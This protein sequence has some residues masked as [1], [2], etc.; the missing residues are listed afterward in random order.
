[1]KDLEEIIKELLE[2]LKELEGVI[3]NIKK[4]VAESSQLLPETARNIEDVM[5]FLEQTSHTIM[6]L[7]ER[8]NENSN[9]IGEEVEFLLSLG[10]VQ[11][12]RERLESIKEKN[13]ENINV[14]L[15]LYTHM[16]FH[17]LAGQQLKMVMGILQKVKQSLVDVIVSQLVAGKEMNEATVEGLKGKVSELLSQDRVSQEDVDKLLEELG[18]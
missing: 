11:K 15:E 16:S 2:S 8:I 9:R 14:L 13:A 1:M 12:I 6:N 10:P 3:E 18:L 4:P 17:D 7:L 5:I